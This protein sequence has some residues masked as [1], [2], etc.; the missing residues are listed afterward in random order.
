MIYDINLRNSGSAKNI[1]LAYLVA[2]HIHRINPLQIVKQLC[3]II[4]IASVRRY[5]N[6]RRNGRICTVTIFHLKEKYNKSRCV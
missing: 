1:Q 5:F 6:R 3:S 2:H 4:F